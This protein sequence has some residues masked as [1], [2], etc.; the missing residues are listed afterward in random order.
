KA[1]FAKWEAGERPTYCSDERRS[2]EFWEY[3]GN[4]PKREYYRT[5]SDAEATWYQVFE[6][7]SEGSPVTPPF[8]TKEELIEYLV[9]N[10]DFL[11]QQRRAEGRSMPCAPWSRESAERFVNSARHAP[12]MV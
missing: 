3:E 10:G 6:T 4:P 11:D 7:V 5:Y 12:S 1:A 8:A 9:A 2:L